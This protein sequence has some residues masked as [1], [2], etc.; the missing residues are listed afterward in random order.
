MIVRPL[1]SLS[2]GCMLKPSCLRRSTLLNNSIGSTMNGNALY[3]DYGPLGF[4]ETQQ[5]CFSLAS[6]TWGL[7]QSR[8]VVWTHEWLDSYRERI[9]DL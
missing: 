3:K 6:Y 9:D 4:T 2:K 8:T 7:H 5:H 1:E